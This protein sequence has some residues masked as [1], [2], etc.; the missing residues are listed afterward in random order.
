MSHFLIGLGGF[1]SKTLGAFRRRVT[2]ADAHNVAVDY[3]LVDADP[4]SFADHGAS[5]GLDKRS[6][7]LTAQTDSDALAAALKGWD[8]LTPWAGD[9]AAWETALAGRDLAHGAGSSRRLGRV[10]FAMSAQ[11]F[12]EA[13]QLIVH[14]LPAVPTFH[15]IAGLGDGA[16]S[17]ALIDV[18]AQLRA[19]WP[20]TANRIVVYG[21]LPRRG[22]GA[23]LANA[24]AALTELSAL[25]G[26]AWVPF[27]VAKAGGA[28]PQSAWF[29]GCYL[30]DADIERLAEF[31]F[32]KTIVA[33]EADSESPARIECG[34][35]NSDDLSGDLEPPAKAPGARYLGFGLQSL[36]A[37][38]SEES[39]AAA[40][41]AQAANHL[42]F[43]RWSETAGWLAEA[44][45]DPAH[46]LDSTALKLSK[47]HIVLSHPI[48]DADHEAW[49]PYEAEW[50]DWERHFVD[51]AG[52]H[53][54][55]AAVDRL[56]ELF[57][58]AWTG[59]FRRV[60]AGT[61]FQTAARGRGAYVAD[62][63]AR[64]EAAL[65]AAWRDGA[66]SMAEARA[67]LEGLARELEARAAE[68]DG[69]IEHRRASSEALQ[70]R[71]AEVKTRAGRRRLFGDRGQTLAEAGFLLREDYIARTHAIGGAMGLMILSDLDA[72]LK[73][74]AGKLAAA[75]A[76]LGALSAE[77][78]PHP[79]DQKGRE[80]CRRAAEA[81]RQALLEA[82]GQPERFGDFADRL[83]A[84]DL[85]GTVTA[86]AAGAVSTDTSASPPEGAV[87]RLQATLGD[88]PAAMA[89]RTATLTQAAA[90][91]IAFEGTDGRAMRHAIVFLPPAPSSNA[92]INQV[93]EGFRKAWPN[94]A[95]TPGYLQAGG[96]TVATI[97]KDAPLAS[98]RIARDLKAA[99]DAA[100]K[101]NGAFD[102]HGEDADFPEIL[103]SGPSEKALL[104]L[105]LA[106]GALVKGPDG[107]PVLNDP[108]QKETPR[109]GRKRARSAEAAEDLDPTDMRAALGPRLELLEREKP[110]VMRLIGRAVEQLAAVYA[111]D[112]DKA[113]W[114]AAA[115]EALEILRGDIAL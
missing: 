10:M 39:V 24:C 88:D 30:F 40:L 89:D 5:D 32:H 26:G 18:I 103:P 33:G 4:A 92:F 57:Q 41:F 35:A 44:R 112:T 109:G 9:P 43:N 105:G 45:P 84:T 83:A 1:G 16:G 64:I 22:D 55:T 31:L 23:G 49:T 98:L 76:P 93:K 21:A 20:E 58:G 11:R 115:K 51:L 13:A 69:E 99:Y 90:A 114:Q 72:E 79:T 46:R 110:G 38:T 52:R 48:L 19:L 81:A 113:A 50:A 27:D 82:A 8:N 96:L 111:T 29:N 53:E 56:A 100:H 101:E 15:L 70:Q 66:I 85:V 62:L 63:K 34:P 95:F 107:R 60:G 2:G 61:F 91:Q 12:R 106:T 74:L 37:E 97:V 67:A 36:A 94:V 7:L 54:A 47:S 17:G 6:Q 59:N 73:A 75:E 3:L 77:A 102:L 108:A 68:I 25:A 104:L 78:A 42:V 71:V 80:A 87:E 86:A 28:V 14:G 65:F